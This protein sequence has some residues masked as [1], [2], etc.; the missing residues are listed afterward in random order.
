MEQVQAAET[1]RVGERF[2][3][4]VDDGAVELH[5]LEKVVVDVVRALAHLKGGL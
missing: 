5:P 3:A 2:V 1:A 4:R